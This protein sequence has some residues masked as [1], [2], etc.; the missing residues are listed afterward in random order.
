MR[1]LL[2]QDVYATTA[3]FLTEL[4]HDVVTAAEIGGKQSSDR[5]LLRIAHELGRVFVTRD[6]DFGSL[7][8]IEEFA[9]GVI[10]LRL[11]PSNIQAVHRELDRVLTL[12]SMAELSGAFVVVE[13][14]RHRFRRG[15]RSNA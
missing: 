9:A 14:G 10:F 8:F 6:K 15:P 3:H 4:G 5:E 1:L 11:L 2:D 7:V 12:H 13:A